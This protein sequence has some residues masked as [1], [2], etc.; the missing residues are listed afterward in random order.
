MM[1][2]V[3]L[4]AWCA[5]GVR[6]WVDLGKRGRSCRVTEVADQTG[7]IAAG[8]DGLL[9]LGIDNMGGEG[10]VTRLAADGL[11]LAAAA[12]GDDVIVARGAGIPSGEPD[13]EGAVV[14]E[15]TWAVVAVI[16]EAV[17]NEPA[18]RDEKEEGTGQKK[19]R[20]AEQVLGIG[21]ERTH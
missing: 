11:V 17:G 13:L 18:P 6:T 16:A 3:A 15:G 20:K 8:E 7:L 19:R 2:G 4:E 10:A 5:F 14:L 21:E 9:A 1:R 12:G